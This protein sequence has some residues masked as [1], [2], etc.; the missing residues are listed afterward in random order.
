VVNHLRKFI[1]R[2][3]HFGKNPSWLY[4]IPLLHFLDGLCNPFDEPTSQWNHADHVPK[5]WGV[6]EIQATI[7]AFKGN[8]HKWKW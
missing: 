1:E 5:W 6:A 2:A 3:K 8:T 7:N 4:A